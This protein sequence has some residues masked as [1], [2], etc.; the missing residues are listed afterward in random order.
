MAC[1]RLQADP[2]SGAGVMCPPS[3]RRSPTC[4]AVRCR[5]V[6]SAA[7]GSTCCVA[8]SD[9]ASGGSVSAA[10]PLDVTLNEESTGVPPTDGT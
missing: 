5:N 9:T 7:A 3:R 4:V 10:G 8:A 1:R 2:D 6:P